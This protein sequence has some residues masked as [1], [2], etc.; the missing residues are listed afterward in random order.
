MTFKLQPLPFAMDALS[1]YISEET[2]EY[3]YGKHHRAYV[4]KLNELIVGTKFADMSLTEII[5]QAD[6][7]IFNNAAQVF[8]HDFYWQSLTGDQDELDEHVGDLLDDTFGSLDDFKEEF[9]K[10]ACAQFGSGWAWLILNNK[11]EL[12]IVT[13]SNAD[14][15]LRH[16]QKPLLT[17]DVWEHAYYIDTRNSRPDY[18]KNYWEVVN[19]NFIKECLDA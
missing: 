4:S 14:T 2:L 12:E 17:C 3:H 1:P 8:N 10:K 9:T 11:E 6:G 18:L 15:P 5:M 16:G 7:A 19:L 13:T